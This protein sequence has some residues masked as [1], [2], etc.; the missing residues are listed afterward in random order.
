MRKTSASLASSALASKRATA[1]STWPRKAATSALSGRVSRP[2]RTG[3][4]RHVIRIEQIAEACVE[5]AVA[6]KMRQQQELLEEPGRV[7]PVPF[8]GAGVGHRLHDLILGAERRRARLGLG[9][10]RAKGLVPSAPRIVR[11][12]REPV[13]ANQGART[14][15]VQAANDR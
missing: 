9:A 6:G 15:A 7:R 8:G 4:G 11:S 13:L 2:R 12:R 1:A 14:L 5:D 10:H 3:A